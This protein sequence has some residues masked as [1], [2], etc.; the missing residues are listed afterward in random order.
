MALDITKKYTENP[1]LDNLI[2]YVQQIA[3]SCILKDESVALANETDE[4][5]A[6]AEKFIY[7]KDGSGT[8]SMY[9]YTEEMMVEAG[10]PSAYI[11]AYLANIKDVPKKYQEALVEIARKKTIQEYEEKNNYYRMITGLPPYGDIGIPLAPYM[12]LIPE[13]ETVDAVYVH[14]LGTNGARMLKKYGALDVIKSDY[15]D[16]K[17]LDYIT[18]GIDIYKARRAFDKQI[19]YSKSCGVVEIDD[20]FHDKFEISRMFVERAV[21]SDAIEFNSEHY[22]AFL[23]MY[24]LFLTINDCVVE[25]QDR[26]VK[27]D[28]LDNRCCKYIFDMYGVPYYDSI[29]L[30]YQIILVKNINALVQ[31]KSSPRDMLDL[32]TYFQSDDVEVN[33]YLLMRN[34][35]Y[36]D[37]GNPIYTTTE[38]VDSIQNGILKRKT[39]TLNNINNFSNIEIPWPFLYFLN[40]GNKMYIWIDDIKQLEENYEIYDYN[41]LNFK[42]VDLDTSKSTHTVRFEFYY[43]NTTVDNEYRPD[44]SS[45]VKIH[46]QTFDEHTPAV[47]TYNLSLP[48][49]NYLNDGNDIIVSVNTTIL[50][51]SMY[52]VNKSTKKLTIDSNIDLTGRKVNILY[53]YSDNQQT[54][55]YQDYVVATSNGQA[56]FNIPEPFKYYT[57]HGNS[58]FVTIGD[59]FIDPTRYTINYV[60]ATIT[61]LDPS[62][63]ISGRSVVF[64]FVYNEN[65]VYD[66]IDICH[67]SET[68]TATSQ[69][70]VDF[71]LHPPIENYDAKGFKVYVELLD[72]YLDDA[73]YQV[74]GNKLVL[75]NLNM[76]LEIGD[77]ITFHYYYTNAQKH[78]K[79]LVK[80]YK[81][82][83]KFQSEF[84][85]DFPD[86]DYF[87]KGNKIIVDSAG[88]PL[89]ENIDYRINGN[90]ITILDPDYRPYLKQKLCVEYIYTEEVENSIKIFQSTEIVR[91]DNP[92]KVWM[93]VPFYPYQETGHNVVVINHTTY[94]SD[95]CKTI[96]NYSPY[97]QFVNGSITTGAP[98]TFL[99]FCNKTYWKNKE[100]MITV[101][102]STKSISDLI[103]GLLPVPEPFNNF[104]SNDWPYFIDSNKKWINSNEYDLVN[105]LMIFNDSSRAQALRNFTFTFLYKNCSPWLYLDV[106]DGT[107]YGEDL[108]SDFDLYFLKMPLSTFTNLSRIV[109]KQEYVKSYDS[110]AIGDK[111][112]HGPDGSVKK[113]KSRYEEVKSAILKKKFNYTRTK[114]ISLDYLMDVSEASFQIA[115]FYNMLW[116]DVFKE[117]KLNINIPSLS[118]YHEFNIA[119]LFC[120]M[121]SLMYVFNDIE[122]KIFTKP[123]EILYARGFNFKAN[124][125][126]LRQWILDQRRVPEDYDVFGFMNPN[127][128]I[129]N[130]DQFIETYNTNKDIY[131]TITDGMINANTYDIWLIWKK[132]YDALMIWKFNLNYFKLNN[133]N[134]ATTFTEFLQEKDDILYKSIEYIR[135]IQDD[136]TRRDTIIQYIQDII[137]MLEPWIDSDEFKHIYNQ[138]PGISQKYV[139]EY[140]YTMINFF[141][142]YK[143]YLYQMTINLL[144]INP[145]DAD[146]YIRPNDVQNMKV[147]LDKLDYVSPRET[148]ETK[149]HT[150]FKD[151]ITG[152]DIISFAYTYDYSIPEIDG[153]IVVPTGEITTDITGTVSVHIKDMYYWNDP[154]DNTIGTEMIGNVNIVMLAD[155]PV[156][157]GNILI[158]YASNNID[159]TGSITTKVDNT[160]DITGNIDIPTFISTDINGNIDIDFKSTIIDGNIVIPEENGYL[161]ND[162]YD[163][164]M[165][166]IITGTIGVLGDTSIDITGNTTVV[167]DVNASIDGFF[168]VSGMINTEITGEFDIRSSVSDNV[169]GSVDVISINTTDITGSA[170]IIAKYTPEEIT[171]SVDV[172]SDSHN[173]YVEMAGSVDISSINFV[174]DI[175]G[176]VEVIPAV[177]ND[178]SGSIDVSKPTDNKEMSGR[179]Y[180]VEHSTELEM[181]GSTD[182][183]GTKISELNGTISVTE[184]IKSNMNG[185]LVITD[186]D[187]VESSIDGSVSMLAKVDL[188]VND[189]I[190]N[191]TIE[192]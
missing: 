32:I 178:I 77:K 75:T 48:Y 131:K 143:V 99:Y 106:T 42:T 118:D 95:I 136:K 173:F 58:F 55:F 79:S 97:M 165:G 134:Q 100:N 66:L 46:S 141:K 22:N 63:I 158:P 180:I 186:N 98:I 110:F 149:V 182:I 67:T 44:T 152:R 9:D 74:Y 89:K 174:P 35:K 157:N 187:P 41:K 169:E 160:T 91:H 120:Y 140:L 133:G 12:Y 125:K 49:S 90:K 68:I 4:S 26:I 188:K 132:L 11:D 29:P 168:N 73:Y 183:I 142:S 172:K 101:K 7:S 51:P 18:N 78:I 6:A 185:S 30:K 83:T 1:F 161:F 167:R 84:I 116:D 102:T 36:D 81:A 62:I 38:F 15:P 72:W 10:V 114:Y 137:Y 37:F 45:P 151:C 113:N 112:W 129:I 139:L 108:E 70:Q 130:M 119:H 104:I 107:E 50:H 166:S 40:K 25:L 88:I 150:E 184:E 28:I 109:K 159:I 96:S 47:Y 146:N 124:L 21:D 65:S 153:D 156:I 147:S 69:Y 76:G 14:E 80:Y 82:I 192:E 71:I 16:A 64:H 128:E 93:D 43:D 8:F 175:D 54:K 154:Y 123:S 177:I 162:P 181:S 115:F 163:N 27:K 85:I 135:S 171:G 39:N 126:D 122:D 53:V 52:T 176:E 189:I 5:S 13:N 144:F 2:Y 86:D 138:F 20:L 56:T 87:L 57:I 61:L 60:N 164:T 92:L 103:D 127:P 155:I 34:R 59:V 105:G 170:N 94:V 3:Y 19:L 23:C 148:I 31:Y 179:I 17:Y 33:K 117:S 24:I 190:G 145:N 111:F 121:T 191:I